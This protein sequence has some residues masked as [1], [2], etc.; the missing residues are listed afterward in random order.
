M[1]GIGRLAV[2][3]RLPRIHT[4]SSPLRR[5]WTTVL[6]LVVATALTLVVGVLPAAA[7]SIEAV[8]A[9]ENG[10][11]A[12]TPSSNGGFVGTVVDETKFAECVH[13]VG[14][15]IWTE[16]RL[17]PDGSYWGHHQWYFE[18]TCAKNPTPGPTAWRVREATNGSKYLQVCFGEPGTMQPT[19]AVGG[20]TA[21]VSYQCI[22]SALIAALPATGVA[23]ER[24]ALPSAKRCV[25]ARLFKI[26]LADP[27]YDPLK[28][29]VVT[30]RGRRIKT[31]RQGHDVVATINL[32]GLPRGAFTVKIS[33]M[34][35]LGH[36][37]KS[38]RTYH[39]C[40]T[41]A[42]RPAKHH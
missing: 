35:V 9:F 28:Q 2:D 20:E 38:H 36:H 16:M 4:D 12:V 21:S 8:W 27:R 26:H 3:R 1:E 25:S 23:G 42:K 41:R 24:L 19:I 22:N 10:Q 33:A 17:Q 14:Q 34:T 29:V 40:A 11:I 37:L 32:K 7:S 31:A 39:T 18:G 15:E 13:P 5:R 6:L 30:I